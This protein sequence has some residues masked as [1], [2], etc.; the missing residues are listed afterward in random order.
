MEK[1][2]I[3]QAINL[4]K[5]KRQRRKQ[6]FNELVLPRVKELMRLRGYSWEKAKV[7]AMKE[8]LLFS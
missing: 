1:V 5:Q 4:D 3:Q 7:F 8:T 6:V 2:N